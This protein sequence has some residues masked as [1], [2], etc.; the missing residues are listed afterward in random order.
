M[1]KRQ[2]T[3]RLLPAA[4]F[5]VALVAL[6]TGC[7][8]TALQPGTG[9]ISFRLR[10]KGEADL[11]LHVTDPN[12][13]HTGI[14]G[15]GNT[16]SPEEQEALRLRRLAELRGE[17]VRP[18]GILD[19]DCN[20]GPSQMCDRP[21]ENV[22]WKPGSAPDGTFEVWVVLFRQPPKQAPVDFV[23]EVRRG[24][25]VVETHRGTVQGRY[26]TSE[27]FRVVYGEPAEE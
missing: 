19:V 15:P 8:S 16:P 5:V 26:E 10:W 22:Y 24:Q 13:H 17:P 25:T 27:R 11:D 4:L 20:A 1:P 9:D 6:H 7:A 23:L 2:T 14:V 21:I 3:I 18:I 12:D